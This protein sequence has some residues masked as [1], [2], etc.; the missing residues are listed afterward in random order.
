MLALLHTSVQFVG[1]IQRQPVTG[2][3]ALGSQQ[4]HVQATVGFPANEI[5]RQFG[6]PRLA[7]RCYALFQLADNLV[8][9]D[10]VYVTAMIHWIAP[11]AHF[12]EK[13]ANLSVK[14]MQIKEI[15][16]LDNGLTSVASYV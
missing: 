3:V 6:S 15:L 1:L 4:E 8:C 7:P 10:L 11:S 12:P 5:E 14:Y 13:S 16:P 9:D 2:C